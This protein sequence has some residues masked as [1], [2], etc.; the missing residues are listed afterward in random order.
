[1]RVRVCLA[2]PGGCEGGAGMM[3][4]CRGYLFVCAVLC[5]GS[6]GLRKDWG[7]VVGCVCAC[8]YCY[9][10]VS[11][12]ACQRASERVCMPAG[13]CT[14]AR[15]CSCVC[16]P[17][18]LPTCPRAQVSACLRARAGKVGIPWER[19]S[20]CMAKYDGHCIVYLHTCMCVCVC[21]CMCVWVCWHCGY[22]CAAFQSAFGVLATS[23]CLWVS[24]YAC[25]TCTRVFLRGFGV[26]ASLW[27]CVYVY[28]AILCVPCG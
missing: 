18:C 1:M 9:I 25:L 7:V 13:L 3:C 22:L 27:L 28:E 6:E 23:W 12:C 19:E 14:Y 21:V 4:W 10:C 8:L 24:M 17:A 2:V 20:V 26:S 11:W 16:L 5:G 15:S